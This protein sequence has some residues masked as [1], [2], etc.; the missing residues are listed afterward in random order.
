MAPSPHEYC[1]IGDDLPT[2]VA[3]MGG[4]GDDVDEST[5]LNVASSA[6]HTVGVDMQGVLTWPYLRDGRTGLSGISDTDGVSNA[7][8]KLEHG[9]DNCDDACGENGT[10]SG[11]F[12][13]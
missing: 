9:G 5:L 1:R 12:E 10:K 2:G 8:F 4:S 13:A 6:E 11:A 3:T 7:K